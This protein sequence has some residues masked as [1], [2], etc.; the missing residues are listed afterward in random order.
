MN[1]EFFTKEVLAMERSLYRIAISYVGQDADAC[2]AVQQALLKAWNKRYSLRELKYFRTWLIRILINCCK[3]MLK[4]KKREVLVLDVE[5]I[6]NNKNSEQNYELYKALNT[7]NE[8]HRIVLLLHYLEGYK[9]EE[10]ASILHIPAGTVKS[11]LNKA[12]KDI[13]IILEEELS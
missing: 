2:D 12:R 13:K 8:K 6:A 7:L 10:I 4:L 3:N 5:T 1:K 11:R 9:I